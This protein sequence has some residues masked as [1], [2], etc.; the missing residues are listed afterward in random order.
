MNTILLAAAVLV[1]SANP[2]LL[3]F[4]ATWC[5][6]CATM[7]PVIESMRGEGYNIAQADVDENKPLAAEYKVTQIPAFVMLDGRR[8]VERITGVT[9]KP[10]LVAMYNRHNGESAPPPAYPMVE[11]VKNDWRPAVRPKALPRSVP[12]DCVPLAPIPTSDCREDMARINSRMDEIMRL[13]AKLEGRQEPVPGAPGLDGPKGDQGPQGLAGRDGKDAAAPAIDYERLAAMVA[14]KIKPP[15]ADPI[16]YDKLA[17]EVLK[18]MPPS[19][20]SF[21]I[22][23]H[24]QK[25]N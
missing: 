14:E 5:G 2:M 15:P 25:G 3:E 1:V 7:D 23:P 16:D 22:R 20:A 10:A 17:T 19:P 24:P 8:E 21:S 11:V 9:S 13:L 18:R 4:R 12:V 6:P